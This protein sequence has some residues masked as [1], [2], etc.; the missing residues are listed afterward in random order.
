MTSSVLH[1]FRIGDLAITLLAL[2]VIVAGVAECAQLA[3]QQLPGV[4]SASVVFSIDPSA[5]S[6]LRPALEIHGVLEIQKRA[7]T[8]IGRKASEHEGVTHGRSLGELAA[9]FVA[10][11]GVTGFRLGGHAAPFDTS[12]APGRRR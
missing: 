4:R 9:G 6:R 7:R 10:R 11:A 12:E 2:P 1:W 5:A 3:L 8:F